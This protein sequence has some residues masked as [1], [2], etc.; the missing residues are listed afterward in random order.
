MEAEIPASPCSGKGS[1]TDVFPHPS[2]VVPPRLFTK[3]DGGG[4]LELIGDY[5]LLPPKDTG[6][7]GN[8]CPPCS[9][10][11]SS[12]RENWSWPL[13]GARGSH[14]ATSRPPVTAPIQAIY[15]DP[16]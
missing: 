4:S 13:F 15:S 9:T 7:A 2:E 14:N 16:C 6:A 8:G 10:S 1:V 12:R 3:R 5:L 11:R